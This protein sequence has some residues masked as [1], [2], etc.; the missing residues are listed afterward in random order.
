MCWEKI[1]LWDFRLWAVV[2]P[3]QIGCGNSLKRGIQ[4]KFHSKCLEP[5]TVFVGSQYERIIKEIEKKNCTAI[6]VDYDAIE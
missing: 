4:R 6:P 2:S 3:V 1:F 5:G